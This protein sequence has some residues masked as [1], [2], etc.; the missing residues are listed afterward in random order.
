MLASCQRFEVEPLGATRRFWGFYARGV[1]VHIVRQAGF[2]ADE[3]L[4]PALGFGRRTEGCVTIGLT[5]RGG[6]V[7]RTAAAT[8]EIRAGSVVLMPGR[9][10]YRSRVEPTE[11]E[12]FTMVIEVDGREHPC[13][14]V[15]PELAA[16][17][18]IGR[19]RDLVISCCDAIEYAWEQG[20]GSAAW[21]AIDRLFA[22][23]RAEGLPLPAVDVSR[24]VPAASSLARLA[25][26]VDLAL[27]QTRARPAL[28]DVECAGG[29]SART[30]QRAMPALCAI[31]GQRPESFR[32]HARRVVLG[33]ACALMA[34]PRSTT[35]GVADFLGFAS[36][37]AFCRAM[38]SYSLPSPGAVRDRFLAL[39]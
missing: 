37:N 27:S 20:D 2:G 9:G 5:L 30:L 39:A 10:A 32:D 23:F 38:A 4:V 16:L 34:N 1:F 22:L 36:P 18:T 12:S 8:K 35:R 17:G 3:A 15:E 13:A 33:R 26:A 28:V 7:I 14:R 31:W 11:D 19:A 25:R 21:P 24:D 29:L 6:S